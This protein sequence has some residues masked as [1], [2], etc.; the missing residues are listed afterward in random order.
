MTRS[1]LAALALALL[2]GCGAGSRPPPTPAPT[3]RVDPAT[4]AR[5]SGVVRFAGQPPAPRRIPMSTQDCAAL[6]S[7]VEVREVDVHDGK[8]AGAYVYVKSGLEEYGFDVPREPVVL[9]QV[10]CLFVPRVVGVM[11]NQTLSMR[12]SDPA[13]HNVHTQPKVNDAYN[14]A[15]AGKGVTHETTFAAPEVMIPMRCDMHAWMTGWIG[16]TAHPFFKVT[17]ADGAF[18][19]EGLPPG[20]LVLEVWHETLARVQRR[21]SLKAKE[22]VKL[23]LELK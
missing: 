18:A 20:E 10:D 6:H 11:A 21:I 2:T 8:L 12:N 14:R 23:E 22:S 16:V 15:F 19:F 17:G 3:K 7:T 9:D 5:V 13:L 4:A 1:T